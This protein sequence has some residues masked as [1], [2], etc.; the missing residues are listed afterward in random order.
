MQTVAARRA[1]IQVSSSHNCASCPCP[2]LAEYEF[3][4]P[5]GPFL[6]IFVLPLTVYGLYFGCNA[7]GCLKVWPTFSVPG[8]PAGAQLF[9]TEALG[10]FLAWFFGVVALHLVLPGQRAQ[11]VVLPDG[12]RLTYK[13]NGA[14]H[15]HIRQTMM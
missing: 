1:Q 3:F 6:L 13:L 11:G 2:F 12:S 10:V 15:T 4:G 8:F 7:T 9:T 14:S 5:H